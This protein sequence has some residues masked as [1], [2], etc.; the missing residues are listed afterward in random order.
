MRAD[1]RHL[2][3]LI[4]AAAAVALT[5]CAAGPAPAIGPSGG[6][7]APAAGGTVRDYTLTAEATTLELKPGLSVHAW[8]FN[9]TSPGPELRVTVGDVLRVHL[10]N[11][12]AVGT[13]LHWHGI[14][15]PNGQDGVA[16]VT[17]DAVPAGA[18][19][20]YSFRVAQAGTYWYHSHQ[21]SSVQQ[22]RGLY[23]ALVV[24]PR[25]PAA[26]GLD[27][28]IVYDEWPLGLE[29]A[30]T[31]VQAD[32]AMRSYVTTTVNG[33]TGSAVAPIVTT[34]GE[35]V[36]LRLINAGYQVHYV[37]SPVPVTI[38][39]LDGHELTGGPPITDA[40]P[41][42]PS[43]R[44]DLLFTAPAQAF[45][46]R[47][48]GSFPPDGDASQPIGPAGAMGPPIPE[49]A[50]H[51]LL[52]L[53]ALPA[54]PALAADE[55]WPDGTQATR[56][57]T[58]ALSEAPAGTGSPAMGTMP[59]MSGMDGVSYRIDGRTFPST[60]VLHVAR[61]DLVEITFQNQSAHDHWMH[62]HGH[63]F[64]VL[65][66]DGAPLPG[67]LLKD[68]VSVAPGHSVTIAFRADNPGWWMI[69]CHQL[70]HAAG[71]MMALLAYDGAPRLAHLGGPFSNSP[72]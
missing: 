38:A 67:E 39:A 11:R 28:T 33:H 5:A 27:R 66:R 69:H 31:P 41:L 6:I 19:A 36:R 49:P 9:G 44:V 22:D 46:L 24:L 57:F 60:P 64:R 21:D 54:R 56:T 20:V 10:R 48:V 26:V 45:S 2:R 35:T 61:G 29:T 34:P 13:T 53:L 65:L 55:E 63:F 40:I 72:D 42:G 15:L 23:G 50:H 14:D 70:L 68:T 3:T 59:G 32:F 47:L 52:D 8:T 16:G 17:Q 18:T 51:H 37:E 7:D 43:E 71:G 30:K 1:R 12:L 25:E 58:M 62:L 4:A